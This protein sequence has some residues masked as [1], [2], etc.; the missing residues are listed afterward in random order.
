MKQ[1][2]TLG[3]EQLKSYSKPYHWNWWKHFL[4]PKSYYHWIKCFCQRG[5]YGHADCD[6][7]NA[8]SYLETILLGV[9]TDLKKHAHGYPNCLVDSL[10]EDHII[11]KDANIDIRFEK[12]QGILSGIIEGLEASLELKQENTIPDGI[13]SKGPWK[14]ELLEDGYYELID[15]SHHV[16]DRTAYE[17]WRAPL[18]I[19]RKRA[20]LLITK[21]WINLWD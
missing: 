8:N 13:Y 6:Y 2:Y 17:L 19:K 16:F 7:W 3:F 12:W 14:F 4:N 1:H 20:M 21:Y 11:P 10:S 18:L 5:F 15:E 9:I